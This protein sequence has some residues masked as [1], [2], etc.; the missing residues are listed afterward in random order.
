MGMD[1]PSGE[2]PSYMAQAALILATEP[3]EKV[4]GWVSYSQ[5]ILKE[6][7]EIPEGKGIGFERAGSGYSQI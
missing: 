4:T 1:D 3:Q 2:P 5:T 7:G 6:Y